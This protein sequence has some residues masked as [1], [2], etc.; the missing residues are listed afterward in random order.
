MSLLEANPM[1]SVDTDVKKVSNWGGT[2]QWTRTVL[3]KTVSW[4]A[5]RDDAGESTHE[6]TYETGDYLLKWYGYR[7]ASRGRVTCEWVEIYETKPTWTAAA[8]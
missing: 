1:I 3:T 2:M 8:V 4:A 7:G 6:A 5:T